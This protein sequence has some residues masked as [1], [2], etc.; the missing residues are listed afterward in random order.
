MLD[1]DKLTI[2]KMAKING[3]SEQTLR[4]YDRMGLVEPC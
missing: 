1:M 3:V 2:G 4:L